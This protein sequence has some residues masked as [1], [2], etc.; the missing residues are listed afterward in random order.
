LIT[1]PL[2][3]PYHNADELIAT[4]DGSSN[5]P[6]VF[7]IEVIVD[8]EIRQFIIENYFGQKYFPPE[9][10][11][12]NK[13]DSGLKYEAQDDYLLAKENYYRTYVN[14]HHGMGYSIVPDH[15]FIIN[16]EGFNTVSEK[17]NDTAILSRGERT[18]AQE[19]TGIIK[20]WE[21][22]EN[23]EWDK[24]DL[25]LQD[26]ENHLEFMGRIIPEGMKIATVGAMFYQ[27]LAWLLGFEGLFYL[28]NEDLGLVKT[29]IDKIAGYTLRMYE[30]AASFEYIGILWHGD[31]LGFKTATMISPALL[32]Q[33]VFP[34]FKKYCEIAHHNRK[35]FWVHCCGYK[36]EIMKDFIDDIKIDALHSF[37]DSCCP[38]IEYKEKYGRSLGL[39]GGVD[40]DKL[41]RLEEADLR[42]YVRYILDI[43][44]D[45][46]RFA[47]GSGNSITNFIPVKNYLIML[48]EAG[49]W[50]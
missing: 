27:V 25:L 19:G 17:G 41:C 7:N 50:K 18:W 10:L 34:W 43:C 47:L 42:K 29:V 39:L 31:D 36:D 9:R 11:D 30:L 5:S 13:L 37:E 46:G 24:I 12:I 28:I 44:M 3:N 4:V 15:D 16:L 26:Y 49:K 8:E 20:N 40:V 32:R 45:G 14:F 35:K 6:G 23:F 38:V 2:K 33:L 22:F 1:I 21:D 48:D